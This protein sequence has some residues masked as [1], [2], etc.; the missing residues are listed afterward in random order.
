MK[1]GRW[2]KH[3]NQRN[4]HM[5]N[6]VY[7]HLTSINHQLTNVVVPYVGTDTLNEC[8]FVSRD[9]KCNVLCKYIKLLCSDRLTV[10][11]RVQ[12]VSVSVALME[13][14]KIAVPDV[15]CE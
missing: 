6:T 5:L 12:I 3:G 13:W 8:G 4:N 2:Y 7:L 15:S 1:T 9:S 11:L 10:C 14:V